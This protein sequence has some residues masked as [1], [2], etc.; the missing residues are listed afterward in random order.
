VDEGEQI[1]N[2]VYWLFGSAL[3]RFLQIGDERTNFAAGGFGL[4]LQLIKISFGD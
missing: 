2:L 3:S 1:G 4:G